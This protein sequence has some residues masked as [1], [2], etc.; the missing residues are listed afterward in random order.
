MN[1]VFPVFYLCVR[2]VNDLLPYS[3]EFMNHFSVI[4]S[5]NSFAHLVDFFCVSVNELMNDKC[6]HSI[7][8]FD[9]SFREKFFVINDINNRVSPI[10]K[11]QNLPCSEF[12]S[13]FFLPSTK[14]SYQ[15]LFFG[16]KFRS[17]KAN[18]NEKNELQN[19]N[20]NI[21]GSLK[22]STA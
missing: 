2:F 12:Q 17:K 16:W 8:S 1:Q 19:K 21:Q 20:N 6:E 3:L 15:S 14:V 4:F 5:A 11:I 10:R 18:P 9:D 7:H 13:L 22:I